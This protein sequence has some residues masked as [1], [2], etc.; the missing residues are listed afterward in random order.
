MINVI[1][2]FPRKFL[3]ITPLRRLLMKP[4]LSIFA[5]FAA[6]SLA[7]AQ[8]SPVTSS[9]KSVGLFKNGVVVVQEEISVPGGGRYLLEQ[10]PTPIHG[11]F[12][13]E[14]DAVVETTVTQRSVAEPLDE[15]Q[16][17]DFQKDF[18]GQKITVHFSVEGKENIAGTVAAIPEI[19]PNRMVGRSRV[20]AQSS[21]V[22]SYTMGLMRR[23]AFS[24]DQQL[25]VD[26]ENGQTFLTGSSILAIDV[27]KKIEKVLRKRNVMI[28]DVKSE[29][30]A[31]ITL[32]YLT[33][34]ITWAPAYRID[35]TDPKRLTVEQTAVIVNELRELKNTEIAL[36]SG[37]PKIECEN[38]DAPFSPGASLAG[39]FQQLANRS[40]AGSGSSMMTQQAITYNRNIALNDY[41]PS[42][43]GEDAAAGISAEG[44]DIHLQKIG[45]KSMS[46]GDSLFLSNGKGTSDYERI[47]E[48]TVPDTRDAW[49]RYVD[50]DRQGGKKDSDPWDMLRFRN[51]L[52]FPMTTAPATI[53]S[54]N[55]FFGQN[56]SF[57]AGPGEMTKIPVTKSMSVRVK[58]TESERVGN[59]GLPAQ[60]VQS[61]SPVKTKVV[62]DVKYVSIDGYNYREATIDA[63][64]TIVNRRAEPVKMLVSRRFSG[65]L[66]SQIKGAAVRALNEDLSG[67]NRKYELQWEFTLASGETKKLEY[68]YVVLIRN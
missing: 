49:G 9:L 5:L 55:T 53:V 66:E 48:W 61:V 15:G 4:I 59:N 1:V 17:L 8:E 56:T 64:L 32:F 39:F 34:G 12:F 26:T 62:K 30:P 40:R 21:D 58:S 67:V 45:K 20:Y 2:I 46:I 37:F 24:T 14:S 3:S 16:M 44:P 11:T 36:I 42:D 60:A 43:T 35:M 6:T 50:T 54:N 10:V 23:P 52:S 31:K 27:E 7:L 57:W 19:D 68:S 25:I 13:L 18:A 41:F 29:K 63:E 65:E 38:V 51:P 33:K 47:V 22:M 28:F